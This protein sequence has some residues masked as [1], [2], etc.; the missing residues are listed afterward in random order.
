LQAQRDGDGTHNGVAVPIVVPSL[1][2]GS[3]IDIISAF[4]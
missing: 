2:V 4:K 3:T 1:A